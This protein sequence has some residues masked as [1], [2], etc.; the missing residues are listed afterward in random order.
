MM[1]SYVYCSHSDSHVVETCLQSD[2][3]SVTTWLHGFYLCLNV[4]KS[5]CMLIGSRQRVANKT[6]NVWVDSNVLSKVN[7]I[8]YLALYWD[9]LHIHSMVCRIRSRLGSVFRHG[10]LLPSV[11]CVLYSAFVMPLFDYCDVVWSPST[12]KLNCLIEKIYSKFANI[13]N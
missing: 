3:D 10:S 7:S 13:R 5:N 2:L 6:L 4:D 1:Q 11:L 9:F 8:W 12:P